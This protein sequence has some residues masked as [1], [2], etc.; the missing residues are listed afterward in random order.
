M[1]KSEKILR[2]YAEFEDINQSKTIELLPLTIQDCMEEFAVESGKKDFINGY[3]GKDTING[4]LDNDTLIG[5]RDGDT[6]VFDSTLGSKNVDAIY[7][8]TPRSVDIYDPDKIAL[9]NSIFRALGG[10]LTDDELY[11]VSSNPQDQNDFLI[12]DQV[13]GKLFYDAD[14]NGKDPWIQFALIG[15]IPHP[16]I[17]A[18]DFTII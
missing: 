17:T 10:N 13:T 5:G 4:G 6:F 3:D 14:A 7:D 2:E 15:T 18:A 1:N 16:I 12:Y 8:F 9:K 11:I